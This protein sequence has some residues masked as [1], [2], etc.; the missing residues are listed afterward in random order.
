MKFAKGKNK[1][2]VWLIASLEFCKWEMEKKNLTI[3]YNK[4]SGEKNL[5]ILKVCYLYIYHA[6]Y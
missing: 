3:K 4:L 1:D 6:F 5:E 2:K